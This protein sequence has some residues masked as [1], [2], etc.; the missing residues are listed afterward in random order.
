[1]I[2]NQFSLSEHDGYLRIVTTVGGPWGDESESQVRVLSTDGDVLDR[3]RQRS[4]I[5][6]G[7]SRSSR[8]ASSATSAMW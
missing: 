1:M 4:V 2:H 5:S 7:A 3:G 8:C 6:A